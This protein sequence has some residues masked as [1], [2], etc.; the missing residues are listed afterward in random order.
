MS[1]HA[2]R[3]RLPGRLCQLQVLPYGRKL[4]ASRL[5]EKKGTSRLTQAQ[6]IEL[7]AARISRLAMARLLPT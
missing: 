1:R 3:P 5:N 4:I 2:V 7:S 6:E